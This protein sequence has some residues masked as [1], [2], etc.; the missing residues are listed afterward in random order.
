[1]S[2]DAREISNLFLEMADARGRRLTSMALLKILYFAHA[3]HLAKYKEPLIGQKFE[4]W[5]HGP[6]NRVVYDQIKW[7]GAGPITERL[8][9]LDVSTGTFVEAQGAVQ[10]ERRV[11]LENVF[12]YYSEFHPYKLSDLTH[13]KGTPWD[14]VWNTAE[15]NAVPGMLIPDDLILEWFE[16][17]GGRL[18]RSGEQGANT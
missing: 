15:K 5:K 3:W 2:Y 11:F 8:R 12:A 14:I 16:K 7:F 18:Y 17:T 13:E 10:G 1:M 6:V 4:A 9:K